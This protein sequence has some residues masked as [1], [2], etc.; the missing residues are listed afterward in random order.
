MPPP[1][2]LL[3]SFLFLHATG[4]AQPLAAD[5]LTAPNGALHLRFWLDAQGVPTYSVTYGPKR[6]LLVA[7]S[8]LG[9]V[10]RGGEPLQQGLVLDR[11]EQGAY[12]ST[13]TA[14]W[15]PQRRVRD[16][17][18]WLRWQL[19]EA[20]GGRRRLQ[21]EFRVSDAGVAFRCVVPAR[22]PGD[23]LVVLEELSELALPL[24]AEAWWAW[25]DYDTQEQRFQHTPLREAT[26]VNTPLTVRTREGIHLAVHEA[27][28]VDHPAMTLKQDARGVYRT[29]LVPWADGT[30]VKCV[31]A[32]RTPWRVLLVGPDAAG[33]L[34]SDLLL[35]LNEP[36]RIA[37]TA[38][39]SPMTYM[40]IWWEMHLGTHTWTPGD[41]H[42]ATTARA[43]ACIDAAADAGVDAVLL[44]GWNTGWDR[45]GADAAFDQVTPAPD[46][47][48]ER[49]AAHARER[50]VELIGHH[51]TGGDVPHYEAV[52]AQAFAHCRALGIRVVK[53]GYAGAVRPAGEHHFGQYMV[54]HF[55]R[56]TELAAQYGI[57]LDVHECIKPSGL[58]R[59][60][61]NLMT[62][63]G[64]RGQE[65]EAWSDGNPPGHTA[66]LPFT[67]GLAGPMDYTPGIVD[68]TYAKRGAHVPWN[69]QEKPG[70]VCRVHS[71][72]AHQ[73]A[74]WVVL[75]S[76]LQMAAD[77]F[78]N[79]AGHPALPL[80]G[81]WD[82]DV[83]ETRV[84]SAA[85]GEHVVVAR[86]SA[87]GD[88]AVGA[89]TNEQPFTIDLPLDFLD[90]A[91][92]WQEDRITDAP[93]AHWETAPERYVHTTERYAVGALPRTLRLELAPGG[94]AFVVWRSGR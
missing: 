43:L 60:W 2:F 50:G 9:F 27:A 31:G 46:L 47:D 64:V 67:R 55:Q 87:N 72:V 21:V 35:N 44:E 81:A 61:P 78:A 73:L 5:S 54:R 90:P 83:V 82:A 6:V 41:R 25:A 13:W 77:V 93:D 76:P 91:T 17:H 19:R 14:V 62:G 70:M 34:T 42:G 10:F 58:C 39:I 37:N 65:W 85:V 23:S 15:G 8:R 71:T 12:D 22:A 56:V 28:L 24:D 3:F 75:Y 74:L 88:W 40:G 80:F 32:L 49:V 36:C 69:G 59:T 84:L 18:H 38:W 57:M 52:M 30:R 7:P 11:R 63:E 79:Y 29:D 53:T 26:W 33:L 89:I 68:V 45:W 1:L 86:R 4:L 16:H 20:T 48:L 94:G 92:T 51:E 66:L